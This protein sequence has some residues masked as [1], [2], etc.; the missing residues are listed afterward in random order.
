MSNQREKAERFRALHQPGN[1]VVLVNVWDAVSAR[2][3]ES[4]GFDAIATTSAGIAFLEGFPDGQRIGRAEMLAGVSRICRAVALPVTA[5]LEGGYGESVDDAIAI[6][7]GAIA[8]GAIGLNFE[9]ATEDP[10]RLIDAQ[11]QADRIRAMRR[12][13]NDF[14]VP[15]VINARTDVFLNGIGAEEGR[16][17]EALERGR[18]YHSAGADCIFVPGVTDADAIGQL[19]AGLGAPLNVLGTANSP[20]LDVLRRLGVARVSLGARP[21][22]SAL[23]S[24][25]D[26]AIQVRDSGTFPSPANAYTHAD[27]NALLERYSTS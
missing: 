21:M 27:I 24:F 9:D 19:A 14:G 23:T 4:L 13:S 12:V 7:K 10:A 8:S 2:V 1:P 16:M 3:I 15:L 11:L 22:L 18:L 5:D 20:P 17:N 25:R 6:A 26:N